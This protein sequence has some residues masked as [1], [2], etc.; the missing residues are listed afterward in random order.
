MAC[1]TTSASGSAMGWE[2][3]QSQASICQDSC[4]SGFTLLVWCD[5]VAAR[6]SI[7]KPSISQKKTTKK[8][9]PTQKPLKSNYII[10]DNWLLEG[11]VLDSGAHFGT[12]QCKMGN[13]SFCPGFCAA[14]HLCVLP[15]QISFEGYSTQTSKDWGAWML[16][17]TETQY[18]WYDPH[19]LLTNI[20]S[21]H[22]CS[23]EA[24][25]FSNPT[26]AESTPLN[27]SVST[28]LGSCKCVGG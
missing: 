20:L 9:K 6:W 1:N 17:T 22:P 23:A 25:R 7:R 8:K 11:L 26:Q 24:S 14:I 10:T 13:N 21:L 3:E 16:V 28:F 12:P 2:T 19:C 4:P 18:D 15:N 5:N 27:L